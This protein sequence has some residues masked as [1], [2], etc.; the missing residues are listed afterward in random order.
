MAVPR[1]VVPLASNVSTAPRPM[2]P[3]PTTIVWSFTWALG[4]QPADPIV[5]QPSGTVSTT[6]LPLTTTITVA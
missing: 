3:Y 2:V 4:D 6:L 5:H 1:L